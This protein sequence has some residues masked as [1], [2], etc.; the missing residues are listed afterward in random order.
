M[1]IE[2]KQVMLKN[3]EKELGHTLTVDNMN[4]VLKIIADELG[5]YNLEQVDNCE[6]DLDSNDMLDAFYLQKNQKGVLLK[7]QNVIIILLNGFQHL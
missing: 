4:E 1:S 2:T 7:L 3:L 6:F 5:S